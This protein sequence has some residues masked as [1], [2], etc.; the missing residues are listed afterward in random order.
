MNKVILM[1]RLTADPQVSY[2][3]KN[4]DMAIA[5]YTLAVDRR[6]AKKEEGKDNTDFIRCVAFGKSAEWCEKYFHMGQRV[7]VE[8][9]LRVTRYEDKEDGKTKYSTDVIIDTQEFADSKQTGN[10]NKSQDDSV[11][12]GFMN[13]PEG[14]DDEELPFN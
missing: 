10:N 7:L 8:G 1:G 6:M 11:M 5:R 13:I 2:S 4:S 3:T 14:I 12:D 9:R